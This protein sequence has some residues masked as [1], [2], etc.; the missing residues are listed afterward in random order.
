[1]AIELSCILFI[2]LHGWN[3]AKI[4]SFTLGERIVYIS[5]INFVVFGLFVSRALLLFGFL[6]FGRFETWEYEAFCLGLQRV[7][8]SL[9]LSQQLLNELIVSLL[10][11]LI[12]ACHHLDIVVVNQ[13]DF[14]EV[15]YVRQL[16]C[17]IG[18]EK[19]TDRLS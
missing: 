9:L 5:V 8:V 3:S 16:P 17:F 19:I 12:H 10:Q 2:A 11:L 14:F 1:M 13:V 18:E 6:F 4:L 15:Q 7:V